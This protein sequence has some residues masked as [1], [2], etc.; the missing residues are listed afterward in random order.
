MVALD[1]IRLTGLLRKGPASAGPFYFSRDALRPER[2]ATAHVPVPSVFV[3]H[4]KVD[5]DSIVAFPADI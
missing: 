5:A 1:R 3:P 2:I 4:E